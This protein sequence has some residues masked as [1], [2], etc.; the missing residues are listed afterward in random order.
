MEICNCET[1]HYKANSTETGLVDDNFNF[2]NPKAGVTYELNKMNSLY[3]S[4]A[5]AN[6]EPN[7]TDYENGSPKPEKLNDFELG[8]RYL[9]DKIKAECQCVLYEI[10][11]PIGFDGRVE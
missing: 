11:R 6:S 3:F 7:R 9:S 4:Y 2:F 5:R 10:Q 1:L 8:W